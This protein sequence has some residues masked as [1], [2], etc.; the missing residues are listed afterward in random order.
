[1]FVE[2]SLYKLFLAPTENKCEGDQTYNEDLS[3]NG[4]FASW[5][6]SNGYEIIKV[7]TGRGNSTVPYDA[8]GDEV[9]HNEGDK[10]RIGCKLGYVNGNAKEVQPLT[11]TCDENGSCA[12]TKKD[13]DWKCVSNEEAPI[14]IWGGAKF[15]FVKQVHDK[16]IVLKA[17]VTNGIQLAEW[18]HDR[19]NVTAHPDWLD[20]EWWADQ[21]FTMFV[22][23]P[24]DT[25]KGGL[26]GGDGTMTFPDFYKGECS[27][28]GRLCSF[29]SRSG[30]FA[31]RAGKPESGTAYFKGFIDRSAIPAEQGPVTYVEQ[32]TDTWTC[33]IGLLAGH[34][35]DAITNMQ[36]HFPAFAGGD[37]ANMLDYIR[38][39]NKA[40]KINE[41]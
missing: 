15:N 34:V 32:S 28:D 40:P 29:L 1:M 30:T 20:Q 16:Y 38:P 24:F 3:D 41:L 8:Y 17:R 11:C 23:C 19:V 22:F 14:P 5:D 36:N 27:N 39:D 9:F 25:T 21:P 35:N 37:F 13:A 33:E 2:K 26:E 18:D 6:N 4:I 7:I 10:I 31:Y 12:F